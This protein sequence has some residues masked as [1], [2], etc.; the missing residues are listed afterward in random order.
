MFRYRAFGLSVSS[1]LAF[2]E[3]LSS[4]NGDVA[5][6]VIRRG[7]IPPTKADATQFHLHLPNIADFLISNGRQIV[8][9]LAPGT[10]E[11][12]A[13]LFILGSCFGCV[14]QQRGFIVLHGNAI[15]TDG[16]RCRIVV[17]K[18]GAGK[19]T[20]A[21]WYFLRGAKILADDVCAI[22]FT[23]SG[24]PLV[25]PSF[26]Q[27]KLWQASADLLGISTLGLRRLREKQEKFCLPLGAQFQATP[28][29]LDEIVEIDP[30]QGS[31]SDLAGV[32]K[33]TR[34]LR[35]SYR[36]SFIRRMGLSS[37]YSKKILRLA[38]L[39]T[40]RSGPRPAL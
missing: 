2:P 29:R 22:S 33:V 19:S 27:I 8:Y 39:V 25:V 23:E 7:E 34:L 30:E 21:A 5:D 3:L 16:E 26:P 18:Q 40:M 31:S 17:G 20:R 6:L 11:D 9:Q 24:D 36:Y 12:D 32:G 1:D 37:D 10:T 15:S 28:V 14:L 4:E 35:H 13:R 38:G